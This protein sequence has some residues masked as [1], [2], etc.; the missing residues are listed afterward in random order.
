MF[1]SFTKKIIG[2]G[3]FICLGK[4]YYDVKY[5]P[6]TFN[7]H[8]SVKG[9]QYGTLFDKAS[10]INVVSISHSVNGKDFPLFPCSTFMID[11]LTIR[12]HTVFDSFVSRWC[13]ISIKKSIKEDYIN[14]EHCVQLMNSN[15]NPNPVFNT[16][17][18]IIDI[19]RKNNFVSKI[20]YTIPL[21][22]K[23]FTI[24]FNW[25]DASIVNCNK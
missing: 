6:I 25:K 19:I 9:Y 5:N 22:P 3:S 23:V 18:S 21:C 12:R 13:V 20:K 17:D 10:I 14:Y 11:G 1:T 2:F 15:D 4:F 7:L 16:G 8:R 24:E